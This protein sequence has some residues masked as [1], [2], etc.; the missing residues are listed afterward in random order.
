MDNATVKYIFIA[1]VLP[2]GIY[3]QS[4]C[5]NSSQEYSLHNDDGPANPVCL[6]Y[7]GW[8]ERPLSIAALAG[9]D[10]IAALSA[11]P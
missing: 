1:L 7:Q 3:D 8:R 2:W 6:S 11:F 10:D 9:L 4:L 5:R